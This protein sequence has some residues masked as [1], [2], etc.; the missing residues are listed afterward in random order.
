[1]ANPLLNSSN[2]SNKKTNLVALGSLGCLGALLAACGGGSVFNSKAVV[3]DAAV[4]ASDAVAA[5][6]YSFGLSPVNALHGK[7]RPVDLVAKVNIGGGG[8]GTSELSGQAA[9]LWKVTITDDAGNVLAKDANLGAIPVQLSDPEKSER[10]IAQFTSLMAGAPEGGRAE[11]TVLFDLDAPKGSLNWWPATDTEPAEF[12]WAF[13]SSDDLDFENSAALICSSNDTA[14]SVKEQ[15]R[16]L[17]TLQDPIDEGCLV[18]A[19]GATSLRAGSAK[20]DSPEGA[21]IATSPDAIAFILARDIAGNTAEVTGSR[22]E[23][24]VAA[25]FL[26]ATTQ[27][28][29][30]LKSKNA[31]ID[32]ALFRQV[33]AS[34]TPLSGESWVVELSSDK[35]KK[36]EINPLTSTIELDGTFLQEG[37]QRV[38]IQARAKDDEVKALQRLS[39]PSNEIVFEWSIDTQAP[40]V[41]APIVNLIGSGQ[42]FGGTNVRL[43]WSVSDLSPIVEQIIESSTNGGTTWRAFSTIQSNDQNLIKPWPGQSSQKTPKALFRVRAKDAQGFVGVSETTTWREQFFNLAVLTQSVECFWCHMQIVGD[44][45]AIFQKSPTTQKFATLSANAGKDFKISGKFFTN[46]LFPGDPSATDLQAPM[47]ILNTG[48]PIPLMR[49]SI[50]AEQQVPTYNNNPLPVFPKDNKWPDLS[51]DKIRP[52]TTGTLQGFNVQTGKKVTI[53]RFFVGNL[54]I[55]GTPSDPIIVSG[56]VLIEGDLVIA[57]S[58]KGLGTI[59]ANNVFVPNDLKA[60]NSAFPFSLDEATA[61]EQAKAAVEQKKDGMY[62]AAIN[63]LVVGAPESMVNVGCV[64]PSGERATP[65]VTCPKSIDISG[66]A[67]ANPYSWMNKSLYQSM[68]RRATFPKVTLYRDTTVTAPATLAPMINDHTLTLDSNHQPN[69]PGTTTLGRRGLDDLSTDRTSMEVAQVDAF[70]YAGIYTQIRVYVNVLINGGIMSPKLDLIST[71]GHNADI[72]ATAKR[73]PK[74][75]PNDATQL[76]HRLP[77][78]YRLGAEPNERLPV[79]TLNG[80][81]LR[82]NEIRYDWRLRTGGSGL[83]SIKEFFE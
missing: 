16:T 47:Q 26:E 24:G 31:S 82:K 20:A 60:L 17:G 70:L 39:F 46:T 40:Q 51:Y 37:K 41:S 65:Y 22:L 64:N 34:R 45:G 38:T 32:L 19:R 78:G 36:I 25:L 42:L 76:P 58:Y 10:V 2:R 12:R 63:R 79:N 44:V 9:E 30:I 53:D 52:K 61:I 49:R 18:L 75:Y 7:S 81:D 50:L 54:A 72:W 28:T 6:E 4:A 74:I 55:K 83:E 48:N 62:L 59:Y 73:D 35:G 15:H 68:G 33:A 3:K 21:A 8:S 57:G 71:F 13:D 56:E 11:A 67:R 77:F 1:M 69:M 29:G 43:Q 66:T 5:T 23:T 80:L 14:D 27:N